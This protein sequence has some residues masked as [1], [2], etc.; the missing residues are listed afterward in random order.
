MSR[1]LYIYGVGAHA[2]KVYHCAA[3]S[4]WT[5]AAFID[6]ASAAVSP[7][8]DVPLLT[9]GRLP[10]VAAGEAVF[11]AIGDADA[12]RR[13]TDG[14]ASAGWALPTLVHRSAVVAPDAVVGAGVLIAAGAV[15]ETGTIIERG[16]I[17]DVGAVLDHDC[18]VSA[19][20][21]VRS[22]GAHGPRARI[23]SDAERGRR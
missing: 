13:I 23:G 4:G 19:F 3:E 1:R 14:L 11:V 22:P 2:R 20:A 5:I 18:H 12:R 17:V 16:A 8:A 6:D 7:V 9:P 10:Q 15:V 21:H